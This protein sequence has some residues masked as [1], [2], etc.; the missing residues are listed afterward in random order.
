MSES[1]TSVFDWLELSLLLSLSVSLLSSSSTLTSIL[2]SYPLNVH[3]RAHTLSSPKR[4]TCISSNTPSLPPSRHTSFFTRCS[5]VSAPNGRS[6][7]VSQDN[8]SWTGKSQDSTGTGS[9][10]SGQS[11]FWLQLNMVTRGMYVLGYAL[12]FQ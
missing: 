4:S 5:C 12:A 10:K 6:V 2:F 3:S 11:R 8:R 7:A 9:S 1:T